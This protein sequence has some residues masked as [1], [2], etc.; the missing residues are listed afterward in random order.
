M[1]KNGITHRGFRII[2]FVD[3]YGV[4][5]SIQKSSL[6][7]EDAIWMGVN[8]ANPQIMASKTKKGGTGWVPYEV[9]EDV[10]F[11]TRMHLTQEQ[12]RELLPTLIAFA[13]TGCLPETRNPFKQGIVFPFPNR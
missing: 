8:D 10:I 4:E 9:P 2:E 11:D 5:C 12:V 3:C 7:T 6:A 1:L 13:D